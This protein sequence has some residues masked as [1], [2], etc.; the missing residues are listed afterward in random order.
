MDRAF[1]AI[2]CAEGIPPSH[3]GTS[4]RRPPPS[5]TLIRNKQL[6]DGCS[7]RTS[8]VGKPEQIRVIL[9]TDVFS[10]VYELVAARA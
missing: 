9:K 10:H 3:P 4:D 2:T 5:M 6:M 8:A 1:P 7:W